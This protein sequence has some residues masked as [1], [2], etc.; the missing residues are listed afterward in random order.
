MGVV[1]LLLLIFH[2]TGILKPIENAVRKSFVP[3]LS[4]L[5]GFSIKIGDNFEFFKN[6]EEFFNAYS[7]CTLENQ[8]NNLLSEKI[9]LLTDENN[10]LKMQ[11][12][13]VQSKEIKHLLGDVIGKEII[14][15][16]QNIIINRGSIDGIK[17]DHPAIVGE[18]ILVGK[19][20]KVN[21]NTSVIRLLNDNQSR[22]S[23]G[24]LNQDKSQGVVE[25]GFGISLRMNL[26]PR[27]EIIVVG[28]QVMTS[29]LET[30]IPRGLLIG[31]I[32]VIENE[33]YKPFQQAI[34]TPG[35]DL[36]K[37]SI[38]TILLTN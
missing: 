26:I 37:L 5:H 25:G 15:T 20:I 11:L 23:A 38:V 9:K 17:I 28:D 1:F 4:S 16:D 32:A 8:N 10:E 12:K 3:L 27:D 6:K 13:Y 30:S 29:G 14:S 2:Y 35:V 24:V 36:A 34:L 22:I 19:V 31:S 18:G 7:K 21:E 33:P